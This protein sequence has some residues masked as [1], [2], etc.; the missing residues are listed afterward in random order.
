V[1]AAAT[2]KRVHCG[3]SVDVDRFSDRVLE[4]KWLPTFAQLGAVNSEDIRRLCRE[5]RATGL[6]AFP[7]CDHHDA[8]GFCLGHD[9]KVSDCEPGAFGAPHRCVKHE[10]RLLNADGR[11][12]A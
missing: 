5:A 3:I 7:S 10:G 4:R 11:C 8:R 6:E 9:E 1:T 2:K 12:G